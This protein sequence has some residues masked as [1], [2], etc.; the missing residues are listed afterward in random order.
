MKHLLISGTVILLTSCLSVLNKGK[1]PEGLNSKNK[2]EHVYG[3]M[4]DG[5]VNIADSTNGKTTFILFD[6]VPVETA[7]AHDNWLEIELFVA[8]KPAQA[9]AGIMLPNQ[10]LYALDGQEIGITTDTVK[11][12]IIEEEAGQ[13]AGYTTIENLRQHTIPEMALSAEIKRG[14]RTL[15][16]LE[17]YLTAFEFMD[18]GLSSE[19]KSAYQQ[20]MIYESTI[21]DP[22]PRD[23]ITLL[24]NKKGLLVGAVHSRKLNLPEFSTHE[25]IRGHSLTIFAKLKKAEIELI[26]QQ[27]IGFYHSID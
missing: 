12:W 8:L 14:N 24:F 6:G 2:Y 11:I 7:P 10:T 16:S 27:K 4:M 19:S 1:T 25:L 18:A 23:R 26:K 20:Y 15:K 3:E 9:N 13:I 22:S 21:L 17:S 5:R